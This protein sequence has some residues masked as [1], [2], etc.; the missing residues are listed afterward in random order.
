[1]KNDK[2]QTGRCIP[3]SGGG[4]PCDERSVATNPARHR[5][6]LVGATVAAWTRTDAQ[7]DR[8]T[9]EYLAVSLQREDDLDRTS[10]EST[11]AR[12]EAHELEEVRHP[13]RSSCL[14]HHHHHHHHHHLSSNSSHLPFVI[15]IIIIIVI[16][17]EYF[18][19][20]MQLKKLLEHFTEV[21]Q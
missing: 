3:V 19:S 18:L 15:I 10:T 13:V 1:M 16:I 11:H 9:T 20:A 8:L 7:L 12:T 17:K 5:G 2:R 4:G 6:V 14:H 21:K